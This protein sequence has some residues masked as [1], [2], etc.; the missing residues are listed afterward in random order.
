ML[1]ASPPP[2]EIVRFDGRK[3]D[4]KKLM[5]ATPM[6]GGNAKA[7]FTRC[8]MNLGTAC[9]QLEVPM[10]LDTLSGESLIP[11]ARNLLANDFLKSDCT[12]L[13]F[14]DAD[15]RF[16]PVDAI[17][18]LV[19]E[20]ELIGGPYPMKTID[21]DFVRR[22]VLARPDIT[23][24]ELQRASRHYHFNYLPNQRGGYDHSKPLEVLNVSTG[25]ML[26]ARGV[27]EAIRARWPEQNYR[28]NS[29]HAAE[30]RLYNY[31]GVSIEDDVLL[32]EDY[33]FC[34]RWSE[35]GGRVWLAP[36]MKMQHI[37]EYTYGGEG[38]EA[39]EAAW[40]AASGIA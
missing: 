25:F 10:V 32:S 35:T 19:A 24:A 36:W 40:R 34:K 16:D 29:D 20:R 22:L 23:P 31:F 12:H 15:I 28:T 26:I 38:L 21:W 39:S 33:Y 37:G 11:R 27:F 8:L 6:Y 18:L 7:E 13:L 5:V 3:L 14:I 17:R 1:S 30:E 9:A 2:P 4:G